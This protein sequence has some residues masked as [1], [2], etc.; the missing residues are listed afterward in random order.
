MREFNIRK[1]G[2]FEEEISCKLVGIRV[3][4]PAC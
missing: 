1:W 3:A 4:D 2:W